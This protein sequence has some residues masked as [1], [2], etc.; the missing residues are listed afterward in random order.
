[1]QKKFTLAP[2]PADTSG[3]SHPDIVKALLAL[4]MDSFADGNFR[5]DAAVTREDFARSLALNVPLR[6]SL[7]T[8][9][10]FVDVAND[11]TPIAEALTV[12]GSTLRDWNFDP[13]GLISAGGNTFNPTGSVNRLELAV[14]LVRALGLDAE[15]R[16]RANTPVMSGGQ[17]LI[18]NGQIPLSLRGYVQIAIDRGMLEAFPATVTQIGPGQFQAMPGPRFEPQTLVTRGVLASKLN[19][20]V[21]QFR[22]GN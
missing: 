22:L 1:M 21:E 8:T 3:P 15:A 4:R 6:Q 7:A 16:A 12:S 14:T 19:L 11:L 17:E 13:A 18:D 2:A 20:F 9:P 5:P 10:R